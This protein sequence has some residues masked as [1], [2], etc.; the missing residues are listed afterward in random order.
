MRLLLGMVLPVRTKKRHEFPFV[1]FCIVAY[2]RDTS[3]R[4]GRLLAEISCRQLGG[5]SD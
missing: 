2:R 5:H 1:A 4:L 3:I